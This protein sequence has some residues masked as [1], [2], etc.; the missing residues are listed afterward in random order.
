MLLN[1]K[2]IFHIVTFQHQILLQL[3][4]GLPLRQVCNSHIESVLLWWQTQSKTVTLVCTED[5]PII[6][7]RFKI[8]HWQHNSNI[9]SKEVHCLITPNMFY[10]EHIFINIIIKL[11]QERYLNTKKKIKEG[12]HTKPKRH[13]WI[14]LCFHS[15]T[16]VRFNWEQNTW[17]STER[18]GVKQKHKQQSL[19]LL[20]SLNKE[21][22][23]TAKLLLLMSH[24]Q[25]HSLQVC[26]P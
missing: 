19:Q 21:R 8:F 14:F 16:N 4:F 24:S 17:Y 9:V 5:Q 1:Y 18:E 26:K 13:L 3:N 10:L 23:H 6:C 22:L 2:Q 7:K 20:S 25:W 11:P 12:K 15:N